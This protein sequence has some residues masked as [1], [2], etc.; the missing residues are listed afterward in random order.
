[1][2]SCDESAETQLDTGRAAIAL[3]IGNISSHGIAS[4]DALA[5]LAVGLAAAPAF[6]HRQLKSDEPFLDLHIL[7]NRTFT[8]A[9]GTSML[10]YLVM[11][12]SSI[13]SPLFVQQFAGQSAAIAGLA[14]LPGSLCMALVSPLA[15]SVYDRMGIKVL[16]VAGGA[17]M[18]ISCAA[19]GLV[20]DDFAGVVLMAALFT[21]RSIA[22]ACLMMPPATWGV[23]ALD[24]S[25]CAHGTALL[26]S[27]HTLAG[28]IGSAV[29]VGVMSSA[30]TTAS[31][32]LSGVHVAFGMLAALSIPLVA[33]G[34]AKNA[35]RTGRDRAGRLTLVKFEPRPTPLSQSFTLQAYPR[36]ESRI[37]V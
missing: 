1:M 34:I 37:S 15:G 28:A 26:S 35:K 24:A 18:A 5:P 19:M 13:L 33:V 22:I 2:S 6:I 21:V 30:G 16:L 36:Q 17:A 10:L 29:S 20:G 12:G 27:L 14:M 31:S 8:A 4:I 9:T 25:K 11:M 32:A 23:G 3:G 7:A